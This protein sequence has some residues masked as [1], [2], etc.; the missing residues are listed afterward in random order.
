MRKKFEFFKITF[1][2]N[3]MA[4]YIDNSFSME[5]IGSEGELL[6]EARESVRELI[7]NSPLDTRYIIGTNEMSGIEERILN[8]VEAF[9]RLD[10]ITHTPIIRSLN[11]IIKWQLRIKL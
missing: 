8:K 9:E 7:E 4:F 10:K 3:V 11:E 2:N 6:S 5:A 1:N